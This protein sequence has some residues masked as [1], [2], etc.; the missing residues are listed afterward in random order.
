LVLTR[1]TA[2]W[3]AL[4]LATVLSWWLGTDHGLGS[5]SDHTA[6]TVVIFGVAMF[7]VRLVGLYFME[8][9]GAHLALRGLFE[10]YCLV[11]C[12]ALMLTYVL[13]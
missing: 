7:K 12:A 10:T 6:A 4:V 5:D 9:R 13:L 11:V 8:L 2:V 1:T 3:S